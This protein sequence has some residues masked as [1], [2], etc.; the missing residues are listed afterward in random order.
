MTSLGD[1]LVHLSLEIE[2][3]TK[4]AE[5]LSQLI[6]D[7]RNRQAN[8]CSSFEIEQSAI[9]ERFTK[10]S[11]EK[12]AGLLVANQSLTEMKKALEAQLESLVSSHRQA[13]IT[14]KK[15]IDD[16][17]QEIA[18]AKQAAHQAFLI[19]KEKREK[20]W[21]DGRV[22]EIN[23]LTWQG[24]EPSIQRLVAKHKDQSEE[25]KSNHELSKKKLELQCEN[26]L[27]ERVQVLR[28]N[29]QQSSNAFV[30][31]QNDFA[32]MLANEQKEHA[33]SLRTLKERFAEEE[34]S[35]TNAHAAQ[36]D[37]LAKEHEAA[38]LS[39][40]NTSSSNRKKLECDLDS[41]RTLFEHELQSN[42]DR[43][44]EEFI[45][46]KTEWEEDWLRASSAKVEKIKSNKMEDVNALR[47]SEID[48]LIRKSLMDMMTQSPEDGVNIQ[49]NPSSAHD[50]AL[51]RKSISDQ[52]A[53]NSKIKGRLANIADNK[54]ALGA[55]IG[56]VEDKLF[57][58]N[59][60]LKEVTV[61]VE[62][63]QM[64]HQRSVNEA[65]IQIEHETM[66][67]TA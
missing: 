58:V 12:T 44:R 62:Q 53:T 55:R 2:D 45:L 22:V 20:A 37:T 33:L 40:L 8:E 31:Q 39:R 51:L 19:E 25:L 14:K 27:A 34:E 9:L 10:E 64:Q 47:K 32:S 35:L 29:E 21:Y 18:N 36:L 3:R 63:K 6:N 26:E 42:V 57:H 54:A 66:E 52:Q 11:R 28:R 7:Q 4:T 61:E 65:A 1:K 48:S 50:S 24:I 38:L 60:K 43:I 46:A 15:N 49:I 56:E 16:L 59:A 67:A 5:L 13:E 30:N 41:K 23:R 17:K